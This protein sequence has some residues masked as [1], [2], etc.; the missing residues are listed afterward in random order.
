MEVVTWVDWFVLAEMLSKGGDIMHGSRALHEN[1]TDDLLTHRMSVSDGDDPRAPIISEQVSVSQDACLATATVEW[2]PP[3]D[4][5][6]SPDRLVSYEVLCLPDGSVPSENNNLAQVQVTGIGSMETS[7]VV[8]IV[9]GYSYRCKVG[10]RYETE[11]EESESFVVYSSASMAFMYKFLHPLDCVIEATNNAP[12]VSVPVD[13]S[14]DCT[15]MC[16]QVEGNRAINGGTA[17]QALCEVRIQQ[18]DLEIQSSQV[19]YGG[20]L[21]ICLLS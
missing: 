4:D 9:P 8:G 7:Q 3:S 15:Q 19:L 14:L 18:A 12:L 1:R 10:A 17:G 13:S 21:F 20:Y 5:N 6:G 16:Q 2:S 11:T